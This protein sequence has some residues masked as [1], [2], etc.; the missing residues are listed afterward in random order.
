MAQMAAELILTTTKDAV[1]IQN[2]PMFGLTV[3]AVQIAMTISDIERWNAV[4]SEKLPAPP[5]GG[6]GSSAG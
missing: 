1:K 2:L 4:L 6:V 5:A 3:L